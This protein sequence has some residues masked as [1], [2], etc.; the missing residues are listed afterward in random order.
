MSIQ[1][2]KYI[3]V[4]GIICFGL[5]TFA[6]ISFALHAETH[7]AINDYVAQRNINDFS[8]NDFLKTHL[9]MQEG[10]E[11]YFKD[12]DKDQQVFKW[13]GDGGAREDAGG[14]SVN[15]FHNPLTNGG[16]FGNYSAMIWA[17]LPAGA[18]RLQN[19]SWNDVR[20]YYLQALTATEKSKRDNWFALTFR[21]VGQIMHLVQAMS[22]PAHVQSLSFP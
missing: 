11:S 5:F 14:R 17:T 18:Q 8:L 9:G 16:L 22:V 12:S 2:R 10:T 3:F 20:D 13:I 19:Y 7:K 15:H 6:H 1:I 21:G 4:S